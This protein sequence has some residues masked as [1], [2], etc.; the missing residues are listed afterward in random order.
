M[1]SSLFCTCP[2]RH[3]RR[4]S[5][6]IVIHPG[7]RYIRLGRASEVNPI[8]VPCVVARKWKLP[9]QKEGRVNLVSR[10][11]KK[12]EENINVTNG[13]ETAQSPEKDPVR[14]SSIQLRIVLLKFHL[15]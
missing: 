2:L 14:V 3:E 9:I 6:V 10:P 5:Q 7:S 15:V 11:K 4:G 13:Q 8:Q 1:L 12:G